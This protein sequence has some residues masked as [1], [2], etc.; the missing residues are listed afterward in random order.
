M[1]FNIHE[2]LKNKREYRKRAAVN[3]SDNVYEQLRV[4]IVR[5][6]REAG[7]ISSAAKQLGVEIMKC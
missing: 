3:C 7:D 4:R 1:S 2:Y 5:V 6:V